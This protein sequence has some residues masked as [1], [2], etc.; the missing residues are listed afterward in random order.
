M[1]LLAAYIVSLSKLTATANGLTLC[2]RGEYMQ[3][4]VFYVSSHHVSA[5]YQFEITNACA[6]QVRVDECL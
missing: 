5:C 1:G 6:E 2:V 3:V 4:L